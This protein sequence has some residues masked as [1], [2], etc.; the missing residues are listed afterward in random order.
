M[1]QTNS[2]YYKRMGKYICMLHAKTCRDSRISETQNIKI[3]ETDT[4]AHYNS[5]P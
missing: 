4:Y 5:K 2:W 1:Q 3:M